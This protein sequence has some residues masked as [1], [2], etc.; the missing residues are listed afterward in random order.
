MRPGARQA[1]AIEILTA[2]ETQRRP[3]ADLVKEW[4]QTHRFAG[5]KDRAEIGDLVFGALRWKQSSAWR[6]GAD[7]PRA[8]VWGALRWGFGWS[9][10]AIAQ[11][12][13]G[14]PHAPPLPTEAEGAALE[15]DN[16]ANAPAHVAG[17]YPE[18]LDAHFAESFGEERW[19]EG[20]AL[21][22]RAPLDLR[23]N[24]LKSNRDEVAKELSHLNASPARWSPDGLRIELSPD[25]KQPPVTS[26]PSFIKGEFEVQ[27]EGSQLAGL[28]AHA[29]PG[30]Q[31]LDLCAGAG[32]KTLALSAQMKNKGQLFAYDSD[33]R[34]L[35]PIH[36]R[37]T[38]A[39]AHNVQ[40][41]SPKGKQDVLSDLAGK[42]DLVLL[43]APCTGT[44]VWRRHPDA[45]WRIRPGALEI[46]QKEQSA[47]LD[48]AARFAKPGGRIVYV[49]CSILDAENGA[50][51]RAFRERDASFEIVSPNEVVKALGENAMI[52]ARAAKLSDE[53]IQMTPRRT[54]TDGFF[55]SVLKKN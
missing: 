51:I 8:W 43:D 7:T 27:D 47:L 40:V 4:M 31:V 49:T 44:G 2:L 19:Q 34:R 24:T 32:G 3:A 46:R 18:W 42:M 37:V 23:V 55:V 26:E 53:G 17:D 52:F 30:Q 33:L 11:S 54:G 39:G 36:E 9:A 50:Q 14:D 13:E 6:M 22:A 1:A 38:R 20:M 35:K 48:Q 12:C 15:S 29:E 10:E 5:S 41:R 28:F 25:G 21:A 45:K 16:I